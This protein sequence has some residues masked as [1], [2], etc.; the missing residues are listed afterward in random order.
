MQTK[1]RNDC[2]T[3]V[4]VLAAVCVVAHSALG[5]IAPVA[6]WTL[7]AV[8]K[9]VVTDAAGGRNGKVAGQ[10]RDVA[11]VEGKSHLFDGA[12]AVVTVPAS[13]DLSIGD[14]PF[15]VAA[16]VNTYGFDRS[17]QMIVAKND[18]A[19]NKR[20]WGLMIDSDDHFAFY[21]NLGGWRKVLSKTVPVSG[22]WCHLAVVAGGGKV[23]LYVNGRQ[24]EQVEFSGSV[25]PT[26]AHR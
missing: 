15:T 13:A 5:A 6:H 9:G 1:R 25:E 16:W 22:Q 11:G 14:A 18:Y 4:M 23:A 8:D 3:L 2:N 19:A 26:G 20:E 24:E 12:T 10:L 21:L 17:Q 7:D